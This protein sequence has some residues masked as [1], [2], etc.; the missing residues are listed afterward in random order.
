MPAIFDYEQTKQMLWRER[1]TSRVLNLQRRATLAVFG[2]GTFAAYRPSQ[3]YAE[4]YLSREDLNQL[5]DE[6]VVGDICTVFLRGTGPGGTSSSTAAAP[7]S[8][9]TSSPG[10]LVGSAWSTVRTRFRPCGALA[11][12]LVT[13]LVL[14]QASAD[15]LAH[16]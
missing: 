6:Q 7:A 10:F 9:P 16:G 12:G 11:A 15:L 3:V 4:G 5:T 14:D 8:G 13:D 1:S 2:V